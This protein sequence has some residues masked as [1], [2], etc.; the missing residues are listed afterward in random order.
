MSSVALEYL[1]P[2]TSVIFDYVHHFNSRSSAH[3]MKRGVVVRTVKHRKGTFYNK[4]EAV[5]MFAGNKKPSR[6]ELSRLRI[7]TEKPA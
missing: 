4:P 1:A 2:G 3:R 5:V 6:V 7:D